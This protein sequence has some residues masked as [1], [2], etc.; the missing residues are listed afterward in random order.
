MSGVALR[1]ARPPAVVGHL[2]TRAVPKWKTPS[3]WGAAFHGVCGALTQL[4]SRLHARG[5][6]WCGAAGGA[7]AAERGW[8]WHLI[9]FAP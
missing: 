1:G 3:E 5:K 4:G 8:R 6:P 2:E 7:A 9:G